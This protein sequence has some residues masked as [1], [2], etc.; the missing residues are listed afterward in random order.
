VITIHDCVL[1][2]QPVSRP[3]RITI[4]EPVV[5]E[6]RS[7]ARLSR[8]LLTITESQRRW[9]RW[10]SIHNYH[11]CVMKARRILAFAI[12]LSIN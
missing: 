8:G 11:G 9:N 6:N 4:F 12:F 3:R 7:H 10:W 2:R 5:W 1:F